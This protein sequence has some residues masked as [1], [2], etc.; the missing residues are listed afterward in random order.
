M[1]S[2]ASISAFLEKESSYFFLYSSS[3][4]F[5]SAIS[6]YVYVGTSTFARAT[7][8]TVSSNFL[9]IFKGREDGSGTFIKDSKGSEMGEIGYSRN[10]LGE[11]SFS[12]F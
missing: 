1:P 2:L 7:T 12:S 4:F 10:S 8:S 6:R 3:C 9:A 11:N 5:K